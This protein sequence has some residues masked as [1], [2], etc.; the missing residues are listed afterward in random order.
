MVPRQYENG[1]IPVYFGETFSCEPILPVRA[2]LELQQL[3][4]DATQE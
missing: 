2:I 4:R 1:E 3:K